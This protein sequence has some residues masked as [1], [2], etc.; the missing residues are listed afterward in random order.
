MEYRLQGIDHIGGGVAA[1]GVEAEIGIKGDQ[2]PATAMQLLAGGA[3]HRLLHQLPNADAGGIGEGMVVGEMGLLQRP[4][5]QQGLI[6]EAE[7]GHRRH[8][9]HR[10][11]A[12]IPI[13]G[14]GFQLPLE[15]EVA[16][17]AAAGGAHVGRIALHPAGE[18]LGN[19]RQVPAPRAQQRPGD[20]QRHVGI[21]GHLPRFQAEPAATNDLAVH[22]VPGADLP[23]GHELGGG[24]EGIADGQA[25][26]DR[27]GALDDLG[28]GAGKSHDIL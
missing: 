7:Q 17:A 19:P 4:L 9:H 14:R 12:G 25:E 23:R 8:P 11:V 3:E 24:A 15:H 27:L 5:G 18:L 22:L 10:A 20:A 1:V 2:L 21:V 13:V 16:D 6:A 28:V 26:K